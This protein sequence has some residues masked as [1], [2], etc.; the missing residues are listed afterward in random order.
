MSPGVVIG[1]LIVHPLY[2]HPARIELDDLMT[3][4][5]SAIRARDAIDN[6]F[7]PEWREA[8]ALARAACAQERAE[9]IR[10]WKA[11]RWGAWMTPLDRALA[12]ISGEIN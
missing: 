5:D 12:T 10:L 11:D 9:R 6:C 8:H 4:A 1:R 3:R 7:A 2:M